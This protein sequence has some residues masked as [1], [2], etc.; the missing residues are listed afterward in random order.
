MLSFLLYEGK[1]AVALAV[2][3]M[4]YRLLLKKESFH[5]LNRMV[6]VGMVIVSFLV[7][8]CIITIH[9]PMEMATANETGEVIRIQETAGDFAAPWW[10]MALTILFWAGVGFVL[11][12]MVISILSVVRIIR[13]SQCVLEEDGCKVFVT[14]REMDPFSWMRYIVLS[15]KDWECPHESILTHEKAH[16]RHRHSVELLLVDILTAFQWFNPAIWMLR[17]DLQEVHEYEAD[18]AVLQSGAN[19]KEYQYLLV[20]KT[21]DK[22]GFYVANSFSHSTLKNR[23]AMMKKRNSPLGRGW[24]VLGLLPLICMCVGLQTET[25]YDDLPLR[26]EKTVEL[27]LKADGLVYV[28]GSGD[29]LEIDRMGIYVR[30]MIGNRVYPPLSIRISASPEAPA[31]ASDRLMQE[32]RNYGLLESTL[33]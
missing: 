31:G 11:A 2:F 8:L 26:Q 15:Q 9:K 33:Q 23:I 28:N 21:V 17:M 16:I 29:G 4:F 1:A 3:Y 14:E 30:D 22:S 7:P 19:L 10:S 25:V 27:N 20:R 18:N 24:R 5:R 13:R 12:R 6:L 32:L